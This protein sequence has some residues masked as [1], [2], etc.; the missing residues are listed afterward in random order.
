MIN[1]AFWKRAAA[2]WAVPKAV[3]GLQPEAGELPPDD[4]NGYGTEEM[5]F[6]EIEDMDTLMRE[7]LNE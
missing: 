6:D 1:S 3:S 2:V 7:I 4:L 5:A